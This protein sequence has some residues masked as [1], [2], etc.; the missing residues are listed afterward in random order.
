[1]AGS[2]VY[3]D[4]LTTNCAEDE[5]NHSYPT[6]RGRGTVEDPFIVEWLPN[7]PENPM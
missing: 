6:Y 3:A 4:K 2:Q 7:D 5:H 1:M